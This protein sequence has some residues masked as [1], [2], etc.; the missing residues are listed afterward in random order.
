MFQSKERHSTITPS[1]LSVRWYIGLGQVTQMPKVT[2]QQLM[3]SAIHQFVQHYRADRMFVR[4]C[5]RGTIYT[6]TMNGRCKSLD[7]N[8]HAQIFAN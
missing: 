7:G 2:T 4:P 3:R 1:D 6:D 5:I 8:K